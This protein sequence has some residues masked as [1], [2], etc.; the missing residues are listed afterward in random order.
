MFNKSL[1]WIFI[2]GL[3]L[4]LQAWSP[5]SDKK[6]PLG[7]ENDFR[8]MLSGRFIIVNSTCAGFN[9]I[10]KKLVLWTNEIACNDPDTLLIR[11]LDGTTFMTKSNRRHNEHCPPSIDLYRVISFDGRLL[12][13]NRIWT[14]W[15]KLDDAIDKQDYKLQLVKKS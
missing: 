4:F 7:N 12:T 11:W 2:F 6:C 8:T 1:R 5:S 9:F 13:L 14:G 10:N 3:L 15:S